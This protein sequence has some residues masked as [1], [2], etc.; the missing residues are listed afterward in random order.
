MGGDWNAKVNLQALDK[1][2][3]DTN[4]SCISPKQSRLDNGVGDS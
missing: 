2:A 1:R 4:G 3:L